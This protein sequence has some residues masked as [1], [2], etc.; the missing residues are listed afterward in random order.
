MA[1]VKDGFERVME[2]AWQ[3][4]LAGEPFTHT[5]DSMGA[6]RHERMKAKL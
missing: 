2:A 4:Y 1:K 6:Y 3:R 5:E